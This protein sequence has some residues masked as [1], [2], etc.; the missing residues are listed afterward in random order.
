MHRKTLVAGFLSLMIA[1]PSAHADVLRIA[2]EGAYPPFNYVDAKG[3]PQGFDVEIAQALCERMSVR[4]TVVAQDWDGMIPALLARKYDAIVASMVDTPERR[5]QI[6]F[7]QHYYR[8]PLSVAVAHDSPLRDAQATF[9]GLTVGA[10]SSST[11]AIHAE[12]V[13]ARAGA[14]VK[15]YPTA[16]AANADLA[17]GR[18]DVVIGDKFPLKAWLDV[19]GKDCC[20]LLGDV[21]G[22][23]ANAAIG[24]RKEDAQLR[25]RL[26]QAIGEIVADGTY[27]KIAAQFFDFDIYH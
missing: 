4:C 7:T 26:N 3:Q 12:D 19:Q 17:A 1:G 23:L 10:Q 25:E 27:Q 24:V 15:L 5:R 11:Q 20:R 2:T 21:D 9:K 8:T 22:T 6:G 18:L 13:Y 14:K 16:D